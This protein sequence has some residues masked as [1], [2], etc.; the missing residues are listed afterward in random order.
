[1]ART[2]RPP[3]LAPPVKWRISIPQSVARATIDVMRKSSPDRTIHHGD[4][5]ALFESLLRKWLKEQG[6]DPIAY[7]TESSIKLDEFV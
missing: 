6:V 5:A 1:M 3:R 2:G 7:R 4:R